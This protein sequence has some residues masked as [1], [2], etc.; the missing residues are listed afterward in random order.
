MSLLLYFVFHFACG[1][2]SYGASLAHFQREFPTIAAESFNGDRG[3]CAVFSILG[4]IWF[5]VSLIGSGWF[6]YGFMFAW[7]NPHGGAS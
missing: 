7:K 2:L 5:L 3:F 6:K 1:I 4:P